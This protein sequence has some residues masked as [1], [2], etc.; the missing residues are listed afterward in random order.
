[1]PEPAELDPLFAALAERALEV[2]L[3]HNEPVARDDLACALGVTGAR[4]WGVASRLQVLGYVTLDA[5]NAT[6]AAT[7]RAA[8]ATD[9]Q[10]RDALLQAPQP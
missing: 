7:E 2:L 8:E 1:V 5:P 3:T 9:P 10:R 4:A 6:V